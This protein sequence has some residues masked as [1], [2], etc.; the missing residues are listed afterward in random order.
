MSVANAPETTLLSPREAWLQ[1]TQ[2]KQDAIRTIKADSLA[3]V[4][5]RALHEIPN[6]LLPLEYI[7]SLGSVQQQRCYVYCLVVWH[8]TGKKQCPKALQLA[9]ALGVSDLGEASDVF[10]NAGTGSG[11]TLAAILNQLLEDESKLTIVISPL[12]RLQDSQVGLAGCGLFW[13]IYANMC[14]YIRHRTS[15]ASTDSKLLL[16]T[17]IHLAPSSIG[18]SAFTVAR[19]ILPDRLACSLLLQ[20]SSFGS[21]LSTP[22]ALSDLSCVT[23]HLQREYLLLS[24]MKATLFR[25][26]ECHITD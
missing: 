7:D 8:S 21:R 24:W 18:T 12:K 19:I 20:N 2:S 9:A 6:D 3:N 13:C 4:K 22:S 14:V 16:L 25:L 17:K 1:Y 23:E 5:A 11:K 15:N 26:Q 10:L